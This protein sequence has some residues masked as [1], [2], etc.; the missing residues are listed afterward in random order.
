MRNRNRFDGNKRR[1]RLVRQSVS[2]VGLGATL[3]GA[4]PLCPVDNEREKRVVRP[5]ARKG[6]KA[7]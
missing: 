3:R 7:P 1:D 2:S 4:H 6:K 5:L